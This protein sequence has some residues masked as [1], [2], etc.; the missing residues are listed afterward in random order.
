VQL[1]TVVLI[2][3]LQQD[4][5]EA[6][7]LA[8]NICN[9]TRRYVSLFCEVIDTLMPDPTRDIS[10]H[11]DILDVIMH[12]RR[13]RNQVNEDEGRAMFPPQLMRR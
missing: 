10:H 11:D 3:R 1:S 12:Q 2:N 4:D 13:E 9:N 8:M 6:Q 7:Q 5:V